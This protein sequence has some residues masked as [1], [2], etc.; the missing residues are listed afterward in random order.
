MSKVGKEYL[1]A[2]GCL[3]VSRSPRLTKV[4]EGLRLAKGIKRTEFGKRYIIVQGWQRVPKGL[5]V[6]KGYLKVQ[7]WQ[8][9]SE[10]PMLAKDT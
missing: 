5:K 8:R 10:G 4:S 6:V 9:V 2:Q 1:R 3:R 7:G